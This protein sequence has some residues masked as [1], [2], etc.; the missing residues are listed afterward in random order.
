MSTRTETQRQRQDGFSLIEL[1]V[2]LAVMAVAVLALMQLA[3]QSTRTA[4]HLQRQALAQ[5]VAANLAVSSRLPDAAG[6]PLQGEQE[7][8]GL[9]WHWQRLPGA[10]LGQDS[11]HLRIEVQSS[12]GQGHATLDSWM[13]AR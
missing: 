12:D 2:A 8:G 13:P 4:A 7:L 10:A 6:L 11:R 1:S 9:R 5:L 3:S